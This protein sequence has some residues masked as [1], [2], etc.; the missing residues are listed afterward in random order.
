MDELAKAGGNHP[1]NEEENTYKKEEDTNTVQVDLLMRT[2]TV[3]AVLLVRT[4]KVYPKKP[5]IKK[6]QEALTPDQLCNEQQRKRDQR[7]EGYVRSKEKRAAFE[8]TLTP[9]QLCKTREIK[10]DQQKAA[11][12]RRKEKRA[13]FEE[14]LTPDQLKDKKKAATVRRMEK[15]VAFENSLT[16]DQLKDK[17]NA[18]TV[19]R[20]E[21]RVAFENSLTPD[22]LGCNTEKK[23]EANR[24]GERKRAALPK[25][26]PS[27]KGRALQQKTC[28]S[29]KLAAMSPEQRTTKALG[30]KSYRK[31]CAI[32]DAMY[33]QQKNKRDW[34]RMKKR[35]AEMSPEERTKYTSEHRAK[36][37]EARYRKT[38]RIGS[39]SDSTGPIFLEEDTQN[40]NTSGTIDKAVNLLWTNT[41]QYETMMRQLLYDTVDGKEREIILQQLLAV[42]NKNNLDTV[43]AVDEVARMCKN[44]TKQMAYD[45]PLYMCGS[46]V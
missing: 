4:R 41:G 45:L 3:Q 21:K 11:G 19:Q 37:N 18:A 27:K 29:K 14:S 30:Q 42:I 6:T 13:A 12:V 23:R 25:G 15:R 7:K 40:H 17:K 39:K 24:A 20:K 22:E 2:N 5:R 33:P 28:K 34:M 9:D 32:L 8:E 31:N 35:L 43:D 46:C 36:V 1:K 16:P 44:Y 38:H 26:A 10:R